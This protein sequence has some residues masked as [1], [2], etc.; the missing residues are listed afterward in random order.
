MTLPG[1]VGERGLAG[2][3]VSVSEPSSAHVLSL[4]TPTCLS[5]S[6]R[7]PRCSWHQRRESEYQH[8]VTRDSG[9]TLPWRHSVSLVIQGA[10]GESGEPGEDVSHHSIFLVTEQFADLLVLLNKVN[11]Y[12]VNHRHNGGDSQCEL[13]VTLNDSE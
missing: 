9:R 13:T 2:E 5:G 4:I 6:Q 12:G 8:N 1:V 7:R 11:L 3:K 10:V